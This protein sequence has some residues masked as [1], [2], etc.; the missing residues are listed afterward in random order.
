MVCAVAWLQGG[1]KFGGRTR[2]W[3]TS[4]EV[5]CLGEPGVGLRPEEAGV[6]RGY[7][8]YG[9]CGGCLELLLGHRMV[10]RGRR[11][12]GEDGGGVVQ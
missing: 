6:G 2:T 1:K 3:R 11:W 8:Q 9:P 7:S 10:E 5:L 4:C 12:R